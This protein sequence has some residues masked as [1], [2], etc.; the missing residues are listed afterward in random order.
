MAQ[1]YGCGRTSPLSLGSPHD[2]NAEEFYMLQYRAPAWIANTTYVE[3]LNCDEI[4]DLVTPLQQN[5]FLYEC[6]SSGITDAAEPT[7][8]TVTDGTVDDGTVQWKAIPDAFNLL[9][10][11]ETIIG[12]EWESDNASI[13]LVED[14]VAGG[15]TYVKVTTVPA[16]IGQFI[17]TNRVTI[18]RLGGITEKIDRSL[19]VKVKEM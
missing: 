12:S 2:P 14:G 6:V 17:L 5:G 3:K 1:V 4:G 15:R 7:W 13:T 9:Y 8:P 11:G 10:S 18:Q 16:T 19:K